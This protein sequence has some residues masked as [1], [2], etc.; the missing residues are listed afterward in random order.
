MDLMLPEASIRLHQACGR[1]IR[2]EEDTG[3]ITILDRRIITKRYGKQLLA[4]LPSFA[5]GF[6]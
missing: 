3:R 6:S 5:R 2:T 4:D 1:L